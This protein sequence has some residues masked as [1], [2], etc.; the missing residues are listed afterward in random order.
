MKK[1]VIIKT[2]R[3]RKADLERLERLKQLTGKSL[4]EIVREAV[5]K[6]HRQKE[7]EERK[8]RKHYIEIEIE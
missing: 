7:R 2:I 3:L 5:K 1:K 6:Y 4:S 8:I